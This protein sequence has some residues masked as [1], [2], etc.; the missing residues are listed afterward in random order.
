MT[1]T[2]MTY[3]TNGFS[4]SAL[5]AAL[6]RN[7]YWSCAFGFACVY[8]V[9]HLAAGF[10]LPVPW[11]DESAFLWQAISFA[12]TG[13]LFAPELNVGREVMWMP[14]GYM[15]TLGVLF[16][17]FGV[18][19]ELARAVSMG[20][21]IGAFALIAAGLRRYPYSFI[22]LILLG[23]VLLS[24]PLVV[25]GNTARM[26]AMLLLAAALSFYLFERRHNAWAASVAILS[27]LIHPNGVYL[28][29]AAAGI[30]AMHGRWRSVT[31]ATR[32]WIPVAG[33]LAVWIL[34]L[35][36]V[37]SNWSAFRSDMTF[38]LLVKQSNALPFFSIR[39]LAFV[40]ACAV[41]VV[42]GWRRHRTH[43][44]PVWFGAALLCVYGIGTDAWYECFNGVAIVMLAAV[45]IPIIMQTSRG[46]L[47][48]LRGT[49]ARKSLAAGAL[50]V[51]GVLGCSAIGSSG[52]TLTPDPDAWYGMRLEDQNVS[53][54]TADDNA[55]VRAYLRMLQSAGNHV[56]VQFHP[57]ADA[58]FYADMETDSLRFCQGTFYR[59]VPDL[60]ITRTSRYIPQW[61]SAG[62]AVS[63]KR[64]GLL[65]M[66]AQ[67]TLSMRDSTESL[68]VYDYN[69]SSAPFMVAKRAGR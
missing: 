8:G 48:A 16:K 63:L 14:P 31:S 9:L 42:Y 67:Q 46:W 20:C 30:L 37:G 56:L 59:F 1:K 35:V 38:Q 40:A 61:Y 39:N 60:Y 57:E 49:L 25:A 28:V 69:Q 64:M 17:I 11:P 10:S 5:F 65:T 53:Y 34:Y 18:S 51:F 66:S 41:A 36:H 24:A 29:V 55:T 23:V 33:A 2:T 50:F 62:F 4:R 21:V 68:V 6:R 54:I 32:S 52:N 44:L 12:H 26:D 27:P 15:I 58:L 7:A 3:S 22:T 45:V 47:P 19:F 43:A 13:T